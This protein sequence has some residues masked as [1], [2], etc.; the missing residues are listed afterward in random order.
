MVIACNT[1]LMWSW[2]NYGLVLALSLLIY[3]GTSLP[4]NGQ[5]TAPTLLPCGCA[6]LRSMG[7]LGVWPRCSPSVS[8]G[9]PPPCLALGREQPLAASL[10]LNLCESQQ[11]QPAQA[12]WE[13]MYPPSSHVLT[14]TPLSTSVSLQ[15]ST[16]VSAVRINHLH[17]HNIWSCHKGHTDVDRRAINV[18]LCM[19]QFSCVSRVQTQQ[20]PLL[21]QLQPRQGQKHGRISSGLDRLGG[22]S[23]TASF[24]K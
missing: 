10:T 9:C 18:G 21:L 19:L 8:P 1:I 14:A 11:P 16:G 6:S 4:G 23:F 24:F 5:W 12:A 13:Q 15:T 22:C 3:G 17:L 7:E 2:G 20:S